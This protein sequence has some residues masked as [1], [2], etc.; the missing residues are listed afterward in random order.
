M[1]YH[2]AK[3]TKGVVGELSKVKEEL[4]ELEDS[5]QQGVKIM[6]T[7]ELA[8]LYGAIEEYA[9]KHFG[10]TMIDLKAMSDVTKRA[11]QDGTRR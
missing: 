2:K 7:V 4:A 3:I 8:D 9:M 11:F 10:L 5:L 6:A 1:G